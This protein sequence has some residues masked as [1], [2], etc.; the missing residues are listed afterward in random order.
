MDPNANTPA[1]WR[2]K[3]KLDGVEKETEEYF[4]NDIIGALDSSG[5]LTELMRS[6]LEKL[7]L[8]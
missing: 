4:T 1:V 7:F 6:S 8:D 2:F 5:N 3:Y